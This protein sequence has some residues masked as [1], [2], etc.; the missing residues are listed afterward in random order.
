MTKALPACFAAL[1]A[2]TL[3]G[4]CSGEELRPVWIASAT[5]NPVPVG[6]VIVV[7]GKGFGRAAIEATEGEAA[8]EGEAPLAVTFEGPDAVTVGGVF[9]L[10]HHRDNRRID[11]EIPDLPAGT[12]F[13]VIWTSGTASNAYPITVLETSDEPIP[14]QA[15]SEGATDG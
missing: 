11:I 5:P 8:V 4:A 14:E 9:A 15:T 10:V 2:A 6:A 13:L 1:F 7:E 12:H 3:F